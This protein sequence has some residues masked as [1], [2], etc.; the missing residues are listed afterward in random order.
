MVRHV[1]RIERKIFRLN[2]EIARIDQ[3]R[4]LV[5][6]ELSYH[7]LIADDAQRDAV[8][9]NAEDRAFAKETSG[10]VPRFERALADLQQKRMSLE[11]KRAELL[12]KLKDV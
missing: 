9:G 1:G 10:D 5:R 4:K 12:A 11:E 2:D 7:R 6:E 8:V 3:E